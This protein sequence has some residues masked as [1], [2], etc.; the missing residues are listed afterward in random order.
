MP[1][2]VLLIRKKPVG[3]YVAEGE[4]GNEVLSRLGGPDSEA[5]VKLLAELPGLCKDT[6]LAALSEYEKQGGWF[7][8]E[9]GAVFLAL[10]NGFAGS[11]YDANA[12]QDAFKKPYVRLWKADRE[13]IQRMR[14]ET[15]A[16]MRDIQEARELPWQ[17]RLRLDSFLKAHK[18]YES[19][20]QSMLANYK[21]LQS[22]LKD[23][24]NQ[25]QSLAAQPKGYRENLQREAE[26]CS[27]FGPTLSPKPR[28]AKCEKKQ[29]RTRD[30]QVEEAAPNKG[31]ESNQ[32]PDKV[33]QPLCEDI[34]RS[35]K[36]AEADVEATAG[37]EEPLHEAPAA[38]IPDARFE[39]YYGDLSDVSSLDGN[40]SPRHKEVK[41]YVKARRGAKACLAPAS[42]PDGRGE[43]IFEARNK[44]EAETAAAIRQQLVN[45]CGKER[46]DSLL[47]PY[48]TMVMRGKCRKPQ[49]LFVDAAGLPVRVA[50]QKMLASYKENHA[51]NL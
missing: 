37:L 27:L 21:S 46:A 35:N 26:Q 19:L 16:V 30:G 7:S 34:D 12:A 17:D 18:D 47:L 22:Q 6:L 10:A 4:N 41:E 44:E 29:T 1:S 23:V 31:F 5:N 14:E 9:P 15:R 50:C 42:E 13:L 33:E 51:T 45:L 39:N 38:W 25:L 49:R 40:E 28:A 24:Q 20:A 32:Q 48:K 11:P 43:I 2:L 8:C 36:P 3:I